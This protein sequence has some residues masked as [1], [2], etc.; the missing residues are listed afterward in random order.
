MSIKNLKPNKR[1]KF[2]QGYYAPKNK[3]KYHGDLNKI[4]YRS[5][6]EQQFCVWCDLN[7]NVIRWV[8]EPFFIKY[9][10]VVDNKVH[11][12]YIDF[13]IEV[14]TSNGGTKKILIE[15]KPQSKLNK[16]K[17]PPKKS[18][19]KRK[20]KA[21]EYLIK[22][23]EVNK[24]KFDSAKKYATTIGAEFKIVTESFLKNI[25]S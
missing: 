14:E 20:L 18:K 21:Y 25:R 11:K 24:C 19:S 15:V 10:S 3:D 9:F 17:Q 23:Y 2:K 12:Y 4:I 1:S 5:S 13:M 6:Y 16:P 8:S 22:E 7:P